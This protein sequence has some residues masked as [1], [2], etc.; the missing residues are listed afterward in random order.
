MYTEDTL[1]IAERYGL[2]YVSCDT[3]PG[4]FGGLTVFGN[5]NVVAFHDRDLVLNGS[6]WLRTLMA[7]DPQTRFC[8][9][10]KL[11]TSAP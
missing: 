10:A 5:E 7:R 1:E 11:A 6:E 9:V 4:S 3:L 8:S 2:R